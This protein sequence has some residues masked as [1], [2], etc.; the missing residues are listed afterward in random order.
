MLQIIKEGRAL[1]RSATGAKAYR[2][3]APG[4]LREWHWRALVEAWKAR[5]AGVKDENGYN[6]LSAGIP[7]Y[8]SN[9]TRP[10]PLLRN[11]RAAEA[12]STEQLAEIR[13]VL[14]QLAKVTGEDTHLDDATRAKRDQLAQAFRESE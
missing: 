9:S 7:R 14:D 2:A 1:V 4:V 5:L 3:G 11:I 10:G 12:F 8:A 13:I 6:G